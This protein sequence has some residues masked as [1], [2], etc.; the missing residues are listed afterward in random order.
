MSRPKT[1]VL[2]SNNPGKIDEIN[3]M[4]AN[5][6]INVVAQSDFG[7]EEAVEDGLTFVE[8]ALKKARN[9]TAETGLPAL[10]DD[11]GLEVEALNGMPGVISSR[12]SDPGANDEKNIAKLLGEL[13]SK[14]GEQ[15]KCRFRCVMVFLRHS[16]DA[17]PLIAEGNLDG[18]VHSHAQGCHGFGYD[19]IVWLPQ[20]ECTLAELPVKQKNQI[21]HRSK[22]LHSMVEQLKILNDFLHA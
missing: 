17:S 12:Y 21:S 15:R 20:R 3:R 18:L 16:H 2:A 10:A 9:A 7:V 13:K 14:H 1:I 6:S 11:S 4:L 8:N 22:A 19:P 5:T